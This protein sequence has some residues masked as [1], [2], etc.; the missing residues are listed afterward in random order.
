M[1][2]PLKSLLIVGMAA[3]AMV[4]FAR[5]EPNS[6]LNRPANT[7]AA[8]MNELRTDNS[9]MSR[10]TRHFGM[11]RRQVLD[12]AAGLRLGTL[13]RDGVYLVYNVNDNEEI[14]ARVMF[15]KKGTRV[16][17]NAA[18][19]PIL[20]VSCANPMVRGTDDQMAVLQ[21]N[22]PMEADL[23][24]TASLPTGDG[25]AQADLAQEI[26]P[27][28]VDVAPQQIS[29]DALP[30]VVSTIPSVPVVSGSA[31]FN[32][33]F[34]TPL[35]GLALIDPGNDRNPGPPPVPE[36]MTMLGLAAGIGALAARKRRKA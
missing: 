36:P 7:H 17:E 6:F 29:A 21:V 14:R 35:A 20:K 25:V 13:D 22:N 9:L 19:E 32:P 3:T 26:I 34:L 27:V 1:F 23:R 2:N 15:Y 30:T 4:A 8:L 28:A 10:M 24:P 16:W 18:G 5:T 33:L 31:G 11:T 12:L